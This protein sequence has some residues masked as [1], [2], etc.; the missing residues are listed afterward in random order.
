MEFKKITIADKNLISRFLKCDEEIMTER[1]FSTIF[2]W[3][4]A[5]GTKFCIEDDMLFLLIENKDILLYFMPLGFGDM[6]SA[7]RKIEQD[8]AGRQKN[9]RIISIS[10]NRLGDFKDYELMPS[11]NNFDYVY[12]TESFITLK[13][14]KLHSKRNFINRF[15]QN[16]ENRWEYRKIHFDRDKDLIFD[17]L[18]TWKGRTN[19]D[20]ESFNSEL[21]AITAA[22]DNYNEL[23]IVGGMILVDQ[24]VVAFSFGASQNETA[25]DIMIE[26]ADYNFS[27]AYQLIAN[28]FCIHN[29]ADY[30]YINREEDMGIEG[31]R[32]AK[33]SYCPAF[34]SEKYETICKKL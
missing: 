28:E 20:A 3:S 14:K 21:K 5:I 9:F 12:E 31:L 32:K 16:Y 26:K 19:E 33:L 23:G 4:F 2:C 8:A 29:C 18:N 17:F 25:M 34:L 30:K 10:K 7:K 27:G 11:R 13:G 1:S 15:K 24:K 22:F 6:E